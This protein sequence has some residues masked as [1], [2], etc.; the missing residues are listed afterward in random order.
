[1]YKEIWKRMG[2]YLLTSILILTNVLPVWGNHHT[3]SAESFVE[4]DV[5]EETDP[6]VYEEGE[7]RFSNL[8]LA[9]PSESYLITFAPDQSSRQKEVEQAILELDMVAKPEAFEASEELMS[10]ISNGGVFDARLRR[11]ASLQASAILSQKEA[12]TLLEELILKYPEA[13]IEYRSYWISNTLLLEAPLTVVDYISELPNVLESKKNENIE[14]TPYSV[15]KSVTAYRSIAPVADEREVEENLRALRADKVW[16][17]LNVTGEGVVVGII[18]QAVEYEHPALIGHFRGFDQETQSISLEGHYIDFVEEGGSVGG[19]YHGTHVTGIVLGAETGTNTRGTYSYNRIGVA[20]G[21]KFIV[22]RAFKDG[23]GGTNENIIKA[24]EWMMAPGGDPLKAPQIVNQSWSDG[25]NDMDLWFENTAKAMR[26]AGILNV[27]S[28]GNNGSVK[29]LPG[30]VDNP[31]S[32]DQVFTVGASDNKKMLADFSRRGPSPYPNAAF[33][34]DVVAP[35]VQ[36]RSAVPGG[37]YTAYN[38]TSM[39]APHVAGV[40]ALMLEANPNLSVEELETMIRET[41]VQRK[42]SDYATSPNQ[43]YGYGFVDAY[44]AVQAALH[45]AG[46]GG[47]PASEYRELSGKVQIRA[48]TESVSDSIEGLEIHLPQV[49]YVDRPLRARIDFYQSGFSLDEIE[50]L[51]YILEAEGGLVKTSQFVANTAESK[52]FSAEFSKENFAQSAVYTQKIR[53]TTRT[54]FVYE[55]ETGTISIRDAVLP[56]QY[57]VDFEAGAPGFAYKGNFSDGLANLNVDP[58]PSSGNYLAGLNIGSPY[59][60]ALSQSIMELP[61]LDL[62]GLNEQDKPEL[63]Y[64]EYASWDNAVLG[65]QAELEGET[66]AKVHNYKTRENGVWRE[67][68]IDL[69]EF[70]GKQPS[71]FFF[72]LTKNVSDGYG[73]FIDDLA[74]TLNGEVQE[75]PEL[76]NEVLNRLSKTQDGNTDLVGAKGALVVLEGEG[77][78]IQVNERDGSFVLERVPTKAGS[79]LVGAKGYKTKRISFAAGNANTDIG[80]IVLESDG[81]ALLPEQGENPEKGDPGEG[82]KML[83]YDNNNPLSGGAVFSRMHTGVAVEMDAPK[84][85]VLSHVMVYFAGKN[86]YFRNGKVSLEIKQVNET[87]RLINVIAPQVVEGEGGKWNKYDFSGHQ[88]KLSGKFYVLVR[89]IL[90]KGEGPAVAIDTSIRPGT[91]HYGKGYYYNGAFE[92]LFGQGIFGMPMIRS[93]IRTNEEVWDE[94]VK[95]PVFDAQISGEP[96]AEMLL[97]EGQKPKDLVVIGDYEISPSRGMITEYLKKDELF[98]LPLEERILEIPS[99]I[100][101]VKIVSVG[102]SAFGYSWGQYEVQ[103]IVI[104]EGVREINESAFSMLGSHE[105]VLPSTLEKIYPRAFKQQ[106]IKQLHLPKGLRH[107]G[108]GAFENCYNL[109][110]LYIPDSVEQIEMYAFQVSAWGGDS[111]LKSIR[112]PENENYTTIHANA[113]ANHKMVTTLHI[114]EQVTAINSGAFTGLGISSLKLPEGLTTLGGSAFEECVNLNELYLPSALKE[115]G[116]RAFYGCS[117]QSLTLPIDLEVIDRSAFEKNQLRSVVIPEKVRF[118]NY[119]AFVNNPLLTTVRL[120]TG[121]LPRTVQQG[122]AKTGYPTNPHPFGDALTRLEIYREEQADAAVRDALATKNPPALVHVLSEEE[123]KTKVFVSNDGK[124]SLKIQSSTVSD[125]A[126]LIVEPLELGEEDHKALSKLAKGKTFQRYGAYRFY[127]IN[128][129][130]EKIDLHEEYSISFHK[131]AFIKTP[132]ALSNGLKETPLLGVPEIVLQEEGGTWMR[133]G[134]DFAEDAATVRASRTGKVTLLELKYVPDTF[135]EEDLHY[136]IENKETLA[137]LKFVLRTN[138]EGGNGTVSSFSEEIKE[139]TRIT[140]RF[141]PDEGYEPDKLLV[142]GESVEIQGLFTY[143]VMNEDKDLVISFRKRN[144]DTSKDAT[145][146]DS[147]TDT[148]EDANP[149]TGT[150]A[151]VKPNTGTVAGRSGSTSGISKGASSGKVIQIRKTAWVQDAGGWRYREDS[152]SY[153]RNKWLRIKDLWYFFNPKGYM[154]TGWLQ[155]DGKWYYLQPEQGSAQGRMETGWIKDQGKYYYLEVAGS[156]NRPQ[157]SMYAAE[158]TPDGYAVDADGAWVE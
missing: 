100:G 7:E 65:I 117:L 116:S 153:A 152:G 127:L 157:G 15:P 91:L 115:I 130:G 145:N 156:Q 52:Q 30:S 124:A 143:L 38:G 131:S 3:L 120:N 90:P 149:N 140:V 154:H 19:D 45:A 53:L 57:K 43:G 136:G 118:I 42:D 35:G 69:S 74:F 25:K 84:D 82:M 31:S 49:G 111:Q 8:H 10:H 158:K 93:Y 21:A 151:D 142:N 106:K 27:M 17:E 36:V 99:H 128:A 72:H 48:R 97:E 34:P 6:D 113:F 44:S 144:E 95:D 46:K 1:M 123:R 141:M 107:I 134:A 86:P 133:T 24:C 101:G 22:A 146:T 50:N 81:V 138:V 2:I 29:A 102:E 5:Q 13:D 26:A 92:S 37:E 150:K 33:K 114:P 60:G 77:I 71:I 89:Q 40:A 59:L 47:N 68:R 62:R 73:L 76:K 12:R 110:D 67:R 78:Q 83:G 64:Q 75:M 23:A 41:A 119:R 85:G 32:S 58:K 11:V 9:S 94:D 66:T 137:P 148:K 88:A 87:G 14:S 126:E 79:I 28:S 125:D 98:D 18:D 39:A 20:P 80:S 70:K 4:E 96:K 112:L 122:Y 54:G 129:R 56:G 104:P 135:S 147:N 103:R 51:E 63:V 155:S 132:R 121:L 108:M 61:K 105:L 139:G 55:S 16:D 109:E